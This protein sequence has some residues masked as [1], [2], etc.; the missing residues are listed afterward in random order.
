MVEAAASLSPSHPKERRQERSQLET[1]LR[2]PKE[3]PR[4]LLLLRL[5]DRT[6]RT[7]EW[8]CEGREDSLQLGSVAQGVSGNVLRGEQVDVGSVV[9]SLRGPRVL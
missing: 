9:S 4:S 7:G 8:P 1:P 2:A 3:G 5:F 6:M